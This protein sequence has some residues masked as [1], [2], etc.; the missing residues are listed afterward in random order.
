MVPRRINGSSLELAQGDL[1]KESP[2]AIVNAANRTLLGRGGV[3]GAIHRAAGPA[4]ME[5][6]LEKPAKNRRRVLLQSA[7]RANRSYT[8]VPCP[9]TLF[10]PLL[11]A[12]LQSSIASSP[13]V[14]L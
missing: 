5:V 6:A 1:T 13:A 11:I 2:G 3:D 4:L 10:Y 7:C 8:L 12:R 9:V 14:E